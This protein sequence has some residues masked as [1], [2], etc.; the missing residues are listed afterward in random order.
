MNSLNFS[1]NP[2][3]F[4]G[5]AKCRL[6]GFVKSNILGRR[7]VALRLAW[8]LFQMHSTSW[9]TFFI[10]MTTTTTSCNTAQYSVLTPVLLEVCRTSQLIYASFQNP[11]GVAA[12][13]LKQI[14]AP[15]RKEATLKTSQRK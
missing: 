7:D 2:F 10:A 13:Q 4:L 15:R 11:E 6:F 5:G 12:A 1:L 3:F 8:Q 9:S 14:H